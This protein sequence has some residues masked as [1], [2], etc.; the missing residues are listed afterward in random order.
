MA[1]QRYLLGLDGRLLGRGSSRGGR[2]ASNHHRLVG[3]VQPRLEQLREVGHLQ[4]R[5]LDETL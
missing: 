4:S 5:E 2:A 1:L 3:K